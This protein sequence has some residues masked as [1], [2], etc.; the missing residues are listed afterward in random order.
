[1]NR[2]PQIGSKLLKILNGPY[3]DNFLL[4]EIDFE[5]G[6]SFKHQHNTLQIANFLFLGLKEE[7]R[8][9]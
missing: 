3:P 8:I 6:Y 1:M 4:Q 5:T 2:I 9:V 7:H